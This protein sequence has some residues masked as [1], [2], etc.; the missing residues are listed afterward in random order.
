MLH[1]G[2]IVRNLFKFVNHVCEI[3]EQERE[4]MML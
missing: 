4:R 2:D 3:R 1:L